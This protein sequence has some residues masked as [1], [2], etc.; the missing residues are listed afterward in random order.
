MPIPPDHCALCHEPLPPEDAIRSNVHPECGF[1]SVMGSLAHLQGCCGCYVVG[2]EENDPP[3]LTA[4]QA[5]QAAYDYWNSLT[6][7]EREAVI[8]R[9]HLREREDD[10]AYT[11]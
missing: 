10:Y 5:S 9:P 2:S 4:R 7:P 11:C 8:T 1:R 3:G 6:I